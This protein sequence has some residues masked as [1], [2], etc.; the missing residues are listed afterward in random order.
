MMLHEDL[1]IVLIVI[2][3]NIRLEDVESISIEKT[4][5]LCS[6]LMLES[7]FS[8]GLDLPLHQKTRCLLQCPI[9]FEGELQGF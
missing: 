2:H 3:R 1:D 7:R 9:S 8:V 6:S 5:E 4:D